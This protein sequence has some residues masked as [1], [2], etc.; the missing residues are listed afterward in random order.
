MKNM[1]DYAK[2]KRLCR[3]DLNATGEGYPIY[4]KVGFEDKMQKYTDMRL[5]L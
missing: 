1:I 5:V 3:I 2:E 4:K